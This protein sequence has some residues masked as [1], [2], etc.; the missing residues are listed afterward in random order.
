MNGI[1]QYLIVHQINKTALTA[2][3]DG[4]NMYSE[5]KMLYQQNT[6]SIRNNLTLAGKLL[7]I[8]FLPMCAVRVHILCSIHSSEYA[9]AQHTTSF[10]IPV[11]R[12]FEPYSFTS[13]SV[14][15]KND[16][17]TFAGAILR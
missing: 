2:T 7:A 4:L 12:R 13:N 11:M 5:R 1:R 6:R 17:Y 14:H 16:F 9:M 3:R 10:I 15:P 8:N